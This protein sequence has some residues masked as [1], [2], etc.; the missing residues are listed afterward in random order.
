V[1]CTAQKIRGRAFSYWTVDGESWDSGDK[2]ITIT[3][4]GP[5]E[6]IAYYALAPAWWE[7]LLNVDM[8]NIYIG[9]VGFV[10]LPIALIGIGWFRNRRKRLFIRTLLNEIDEVYS[11]FKTNP[12]RCEEELCRLR[13]KNF[14]VVVDGKIAQESYDIMDKRI[15]KYLEELRKQARARG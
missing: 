5:C 9:I 12:H 14:E 8:V 11:R 15:E 10:A 13:D 4:N 3:M 7:I 2:K 6:A 1:N